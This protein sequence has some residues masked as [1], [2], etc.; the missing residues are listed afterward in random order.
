MAALED[1]DFFRDFDLSK[2]PLWFTPATLCKQEAGGG[3]RFMSKSRLVSDRNLFNSM[4][5][6]NP[7]I[8]DNDLLPKFGSIE[9]ILPGQLFYTIGFSPE[10]GELDVFEEGQTF[11]MGKKRTMFQL[12]SLSRTNETQ[13]IREQVCHCEFV[14]IQPRDVTFFTSFEVLATTRRYLVLRGETRPA[15]AY[16]F[17]PGVPFPAEVVVPEFV[18][19]PFLGQLGL[20]SAEK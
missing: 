17:Q 20:R 15:V 3:L 16:R 8:Q 9:S 7:G 10:R 1:Y 2:A 18:L 19:K 6:A 13:Q 5:E 4:K 14:Q 11:I 12:V